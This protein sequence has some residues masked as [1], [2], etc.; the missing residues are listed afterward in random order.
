[1][2]QLGRKPKSCTPSATRLGHPCAPRLPTGP[3][4][5][6]HWRPRPRPATSPRPRQARRLCSSLASLTPTSTTPEPTGTLRLSVRDPL[7][8]QR[9]RAQVATP[10]SA[11]EF[12]FTRA[13]RRELTLNSLGFTVLSSVA[14]H[15]HRDDGGRLR[16]PPI[17][18]RFS[19]LSAFSLTRSCP[20]FA[21]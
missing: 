13:D 19:S 15:K 8:R 9:P 16:K 17:R 6:T 20:G 5:L 2:H 12:G 1:M 14:R 11:G 18:I 21:F 4:P 3:S 7:P 10:G